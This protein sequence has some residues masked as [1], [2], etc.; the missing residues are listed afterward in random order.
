MTEQATPV[1]PDANELVE[2]LATLRT[3]LDELRGRL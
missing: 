1:A 2:R 3:R